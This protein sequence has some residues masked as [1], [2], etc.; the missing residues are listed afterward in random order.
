[1]LERLSEPARRARARLLSAFEPDERT[2][3]LELLAKFTRTFNDSTRVP[4]EAH[5]AGERWDDESL[6][7]S[8][9]RNGAN[10]KALTR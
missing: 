7:Q 3:F 9:T 4:L 6:Q 5:R 2:Q 8:C 10:G 1:M